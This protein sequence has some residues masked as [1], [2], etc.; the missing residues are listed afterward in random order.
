M[1]VLEYAQGDSVADGR[2][3]AVGTPC[4]VEKSHDVPDGQE[5]ASAESI[6][7]L[8]VDL[9]ASGGG[10]SVADSSGSVSMASGPVRLALERR[11]HDRLV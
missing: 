11:R 1:E 8:P 3:E 9:N 7:H 10:K 4:K 6:S 2:A 5:R